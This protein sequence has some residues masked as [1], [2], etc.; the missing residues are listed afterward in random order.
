ML[1]R[2]NPEHRDNG[3]DRRLQVAPPVMPLLLTVNQAAELLGIGRS[4]VYELIDAGELIS[5]KRGASRRIPLK[6][7]YGYIDLLLE[8]AK[9][10]GGEGPTVPSAS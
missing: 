5:V 10:D 9:D 8:D 2:P 6:A 3:D 1:P 4:T 7:I